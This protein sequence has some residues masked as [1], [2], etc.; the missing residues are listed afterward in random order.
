MRLLLL[1]I[2]HRTAPLALR[3][4]L[5]LSGESLHSA[6]HAIRS[7]YPRAEA[8]ILSTCNRTE[9]YV[10]RPSH[11]SPT[12]DE[13]RHALAQACGVDE[14]D[15][16]PACVHHESEPA[17]T[18]LLRVATG[19]DS[20]VIGEPQILGQVRKAYETAVAQRCVGPVLHRVFQQALATAKAARTQTGIGDGRL[21]VGSAAVDFARQIFERFDDKTVVAIGAGEMAKLTLTHLIALHPRRLWIANRSPDRAAALADRLR[22]QERQIQ[23]GPRSLESLGELLVEADI[24]LT[25]TGSPEPIIT[26]KAVKSLLKQRGY[27]PLFIIDIA[28]PRDV[29]QA[30]GSLSNVYLY[31]LD[32]LQRVVQ[33]TLTDRSAEVQ[34]CEQMLVAAARECLA[35]VQHR[36]A[37]HTIRQLRQKLHDLGDAESQRTVRRLS[38]ALSAEQAQQAQEIIDEHTRRLINKILHLPLSQL[39]P[40]A[41]NGATSAATGAAT[42]GSMGTHVA[43]LRRLFDLPEETDHDAASPQIDAPD[44]APDSA[45][46]QQATDVNQAESLPK[47]QASDVTTGA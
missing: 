43:A 8:V 22:L 18:H 5:A 9:L 11:E 37:G 12:H 23:G 45:A 27:R 44:P 6:L 40:K 31:N 1:S 24:V 13:L 34:R 47:P 16:A 42:G 4:R 14:H 29:E 36:D 28:L 46:P 21:S 3:E 25:G 41:Q 32:D 17:V 10:A 7:R 15:I 39:D 2:T 38:G 30:V 19:I 33:Q 20:M 35:L 26:A